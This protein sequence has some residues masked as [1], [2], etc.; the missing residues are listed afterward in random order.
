MKASGYTLVE[1]MVVVAIIAI[2]SAIAF[3]S[4]QGYM[5]D[6]YQAQALADL[7]VCSTQLERYFSNDFTYVGADANDVCTEWSPADQPFADRRFTMS[8]ETEERNRWTIRMTPVNDGCWVEISS[9]GSQ[10]NEPGCG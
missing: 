3:P 8:F 2:I 9:D 1:M 10:A 4:Y 6:T 7:Q 5:R